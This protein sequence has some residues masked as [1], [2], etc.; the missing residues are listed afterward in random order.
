MLLTW[1]NAH[2]GCGTHEVTNQTPPLIDYDASDDAALV[3]GL[4]RE[5]AGWY[6]NDLRRVGR[7]AGGA[8][9][10]QWAAQANR[11]E[12]EL[13][14][15]DRFGHRIDEVDF[16]P[17][18]HQLMNIAIAEGLGG[19]QWAEPRSGAHVARAAGDYVWGHTDSGHGCPVAKT[20]AVIPTELVQ[21]FQH[22]LHRRRPRSRARLRVLPAT[23]DSR[24][25][26]MIVRCETETDQRKTTSERSR[27]RSVPPEV[28]VIPCWFALN[29][30]RPPAA[31]AVVA[32]WCSIHGFG[33]QAVTQTHRSR[34]IDDA[35]AMVIDCLRGHGV[36]VPDEVTITWTDNSH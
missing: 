5:G 2:P 10:Q 32:D 31:A 17:A 26:A 30:G 20:Y 12:P 19:A 13:A 21:S 29:A 27:S 28:I 14:T 25:R 35:R 7:L 11:Y 18:W 8:Q 22:Q 24:K 33:I 6:E 23:P 15:H 1:I 9:A 3:E 4:H 34:S 36:D 16:H